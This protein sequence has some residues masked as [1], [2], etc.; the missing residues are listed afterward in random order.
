[1]STETRDIPKSVTV[2][3]LCDEIIPKSESSLDV[4]SL[5]SGYLAHPVTPKTKWAYLIWPP[6]NRPGRGRSWQEAQAEREASRHYD[7]HGR[8]ITALVERA[9]SE[10]TEHADRSNEGEIQ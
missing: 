8:C 3:D 10:R 2:C 9:V 7:F 1:M 5:I 4:G 6:S